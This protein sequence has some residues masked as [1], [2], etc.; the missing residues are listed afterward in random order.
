MRILFYSIRS[1]EKPYLEEANKGVHELSFTEQSLSLQTTSLSE[2]FDVISVFTSD[3]ASAEVIDQLSGNGVRFI[4]VR[5][6][7]YDNVSIAR[8]AEKQI[9][10]A[11]VPHYSPQ[12]IAE[13]AVAMMLALGR[14]LI[15]AD[16]NVRR[17]D[18]TID[19]LVGFTLHDKKVGIIGTGRTGN[20]AARI[21]H[22]F[23]CRLLAY[24]IL[25][26]KE[27]ETSCG[28]MYTDLDTLCRESDIITLHA[29]LT[30]HTKYLINGDRVRQM[31][32]GVM[33]VNTA[34]G[35]LVHTA[36]I[37]PFI[38]NGHIGYCA[39]DVYEKEKGIFFHDFS[40]RPF[41]EEQLQKLMSYPNVLV[42]PHQAFA[43]QEALRTIA[44]VSFQNIDA[45]ERSGR[46][47]HDILP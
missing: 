6:T 3:D 8:A 43:T 39:L 45:W 32:K 26:D 17:Y 18:F 40:D 34:R 42:T 19:A 9:R 37:I 10:V 25:P 13:H 47:D 16:K 5:A 28:L 41:A 24:D 38:D 35:A 27:L 30:P 29:P 14:K 12:S 36:E 33:L 11:N 44:A 7:G 1:Y 21:L 31:K 46:S 23:G 15:I 22:G 4:A 20:A 2:G